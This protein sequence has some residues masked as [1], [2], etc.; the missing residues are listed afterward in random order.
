MSR[1]TTTT[2]M[3][4]IHKCKICGYIYNAQNGDPIS[5]I[6]EGTLFSDLPESWVCPLCGAT[7]EE[8]EVID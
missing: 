3:N 6:L 7:A 5:G 4:E 8:F 2:Q 1:P